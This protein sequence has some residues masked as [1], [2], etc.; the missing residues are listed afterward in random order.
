MFQ[1]DSYLLWVLA[2]SVANAA[3]IFSVRSDV[4]AFDRNVF[5]ATN[6]SSNSLFTNTV[7]NTSVASSAFNGT[8]TGPGGLS[9]DYS[10]SGLSGPGILQGFA[11][12]LSS[13]QANS[14]TS[15]AN[16]IP[17]FQDTLTIS[18]P[19]HSGSGTV[20]FGF[21]VVAD[22][23]SFTASPGA[24]TEVHLWHFIGAPSAFSWNLQQ[25]A[26]QSVNSF[27]FSGPMPFTFGQPFD[28]IG[29]VTARV[30]SYCANLTTCGNWTGSG[31][32]DVSHTLQLV[33]IGILDST[34]T[35]V[36]DYSVGAAS[37]SDAYSLLS[38]AAVPEP[39]AWILLGSGLVLIALRRRA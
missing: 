6:C 28:L 7:S 14:W 32:S 10:L 20:I 39:A 26:G 19:S 16:S 1:R 15:T 9:I 8:V 21:S 23:T 27:L 34:N 38:N 35:S 12:T 30:D 36:V 11:S 33:S 22:G 29:A 4:C 2:A 13:G 24:V 31:T 17:L 25:I 37:G 18:S 3:P 5:N